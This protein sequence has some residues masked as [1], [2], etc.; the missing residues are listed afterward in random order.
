MLSVIE[1]KAEIA[2]CQKRFEKA[3]R[4]VATRTGRHVIG[5]P[6]GVAEVDVCYVKKLDL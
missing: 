4:Q 2:A 6:G 1:K 3:V 5:F